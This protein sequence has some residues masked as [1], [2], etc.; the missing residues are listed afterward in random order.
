MAANDYRLVTHWWLPATPEE[1]YQ[2][3]IDVGQYPNWWPEAF[4]DVKEQWASGARWA[5]CHVRGYLPYTLWFQARVVEERFP[6][7]FT[8]EVR[9][10]FNGRGVWSFEAHGG[11]VHTT[12]DWQV[13]VTKP[14]IRYL[15]FFVP[16]AVCLQSLLGHVPRRGQRA[17]PAPAQHCPFPG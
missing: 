16:V 2:L 13:R 11:G 1:L 6:Y 17:P 15:S 10:D 8:V 4:L 5:N 7:G 3:L 14:L 9:G 12:F